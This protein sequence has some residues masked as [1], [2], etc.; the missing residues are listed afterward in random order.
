MD[1]PNKQFIKSLEESKEPNP[2]HKNCPFKICVYIESKS[3]EFSTKN[4]PEQI[5]TKVDIV[6]KR[7]RSLNSFSSRP[8][9]S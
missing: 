1:I 7:Y 8:T 2:L 3:V 9:I 6:K 5:H 4:V